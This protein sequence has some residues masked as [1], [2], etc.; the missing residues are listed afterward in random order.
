MTD[1]SIQAISRTNLVEAQSNISALRAEIAELQGELT[2]LRELPDN[3]ADRQRKLNQ[4]K[5]THVPQLKAS[6]ADL[7]RNT[8][9]GVNSNAAIAA[10]RRE[11]LRQTV[12]LIQ[13]EEVALPKL[14]TE[15]LTLAKRMAEICVSLRQFILALLKA[16]WHAIETELAYAAQGNSF[17][18]DHPGYSTVHT[19]EAF[20]APCQLEDITKHL[21]AEAQ[22]H[23]EALEAISVTLENGLSSAQSAQIKL[24]QTVDAVHSMERDL[25]ELRGKRQQAVAK[26]Y[27]LDDLSGSIQSLAAKLQKKQRDVSLVEDELAGLAMRI[28][29]YQKA[30]VHAQTAS[31]SADR[32]I[33]QME[34]CLL[35]QEYNQQAAKFGEMFKEYAQKAAVL[36]ESLDTSLS[37][38]GAVC[39]LPSQNPYLPQGTEGTP[40][41]QLPILRLHWVKL[42]AI[43]RE[44]I[45]FTPTEQYFIS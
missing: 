27:A 40:N 12:E 37:S 42:N 45:S 39:K 24:Q 28:V 7:E 30:V 16:E 31:E 26:G 38:G 17:L 41:C 1:Q 14:E 35:A 22:S 13:A 11:E 25:S 6:I 9:H 8:S 34:L 33:K 36:K 23:K 43:G 21:L 5:N 20:P 29:A 15:Y 3:L 44:Q 32:C 10:K 19:A 18:L 4:Y 2:R